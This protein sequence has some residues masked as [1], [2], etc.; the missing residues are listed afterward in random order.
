MVR[1]KFFVNIH[2]KIISRECHNDFF[3]KNEFFFY[4]LKIN[5]YFCIVKFNVKIAELAQW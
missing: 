1:Q 4:Q 2:T 3:E 5:Y